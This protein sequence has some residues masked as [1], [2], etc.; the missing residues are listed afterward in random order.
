MDFTI[1]L[2]IQTTHPHRGDNVTAAATN[3]APALTLG[4]ASCFEDQNMPFYL[5]YVVLGCSAATPSGYRA[6]V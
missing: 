5:F 3:S 4:Y 6:Q 1:G 2:E